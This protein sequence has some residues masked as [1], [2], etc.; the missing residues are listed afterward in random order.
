VNRHAD[1]LGIIE[2]ASFSEEIIL[3]YAVEGNR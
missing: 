1:P 3:P 2:M